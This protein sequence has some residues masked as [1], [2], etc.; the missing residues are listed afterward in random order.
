M[1]ANIFLIAFLLIFAATIALCI[2][3]R[4]VPEKPQ[5]VVVPTPAPQ[6]APQ[7]QAAEAKAKP[8]DGNCLACHYNTK[9]QY[10]P[11]VERIPGHIDATEYCIYC[12]VKN[13][14][15]LNEDQLFK[16]VHALHTSKYSDCNKCHKTY[17]REELGCG[18]CHASDP[19]KPSNGNV[20]EIHSPRNVGCMG[21]H[22]D[23]FARIHID[24]KPFPEYF[25]FSE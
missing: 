10:V 21:C 19:F 2:Q 17:T 1:R 22:G 13:A 20:F 18:K 8:I 12:H 23:D 16:A 11:Q 9:R 4:E 6:K 5:A 24:R 3:T 15:Q 25:S 14:P 7:V